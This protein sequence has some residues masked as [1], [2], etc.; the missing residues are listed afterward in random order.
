MCTTFIMLEQERSSRPW[1]VPLE[2]APR[3]AKEID[4]RV[5]ILDSVICAW[6]E[7]RID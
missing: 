2:S 1:F 6:S 4:L 3:D 7:A 5:K